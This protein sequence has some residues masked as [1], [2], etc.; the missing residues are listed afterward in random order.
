MAISRLEDMLTDPF[1]R[2]YFS[3]AAKN[4]DSYL[5]TSKLTL[6]VLDKK[7]AIFRVYKKSMTLIVKDNLIEPQSL[8]A[9]ET[10]LA[11]R[12]QPKEKHFYQQLL[13]LLLVQIN[14]VYGLSIPP[15]ATFTQIQQEQPI[16]HGGIFLNSD[17]HQKLYDLIENERFLYAYIEDPIAYHGVLCLWLA[18]KEGFDKQSILK[19]SLIH[20]FQ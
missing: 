10:K 13:Q 20:N 1:K 12:N 7:N 18:L 16:L 3:L 19:L 15:S 17:L 9:L 5:Q 14:T 11:P 4:I 8:R 2:R 6:S